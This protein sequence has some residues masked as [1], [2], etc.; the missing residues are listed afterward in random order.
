M[1]D[2][3]YAEA[4]FIFDGTS[5]PLGA[6]MTLGMDLGGYGGSPAALAGLIASEYNA[7]GMK[8]AMTTT[9]RLAAVEVKFGPDATG[10][11]ARVGA[12]VPGTVSTP[13]ASPNVA[14]N[15]RKLTAQG[16]RAGRGRFYQPGVPEAAVGVG[17]AVDPSVV[18][19]LSGN[20]ETFR[21]GIELLGIDLVVFHGPGSPLGAPTPI[22]SFAVDPQIATQ[23]RRNRR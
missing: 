8:G 9:C 5:V 7:G 11:S 18:T 13:S 14:F 20:W 3:G 17:G 4:R 23:R 10:P 12:N 22:T 15:I 19:G 21:Q 1:V 2:V 6:V 16:G